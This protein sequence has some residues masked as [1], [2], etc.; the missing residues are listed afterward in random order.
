MR[1]LPF[2]YPESR[3][4]GFNHLIFISPI[5]A[6]IALVVLIIAL[7]VPFLKNSS[8]SGERLANSFS[9]LYFENKNKY[10]YLFLT[11]LLGSVLFYLFRAPTHFLGDGY[12]ALNNLASQ[13]GTIFKWS[14]AGTTTLLDSI[15]SLFGGK[16]IQTAKY[17]FQAVSIISGAISIFFFIL[18]SGEISKNSTRRFLAFI[19]MFGS[20]VLLMFFGY[21]ESYSPAWAA[22]SGFIYFT[23]RYLNR[24]RGLIYIFIFLLIGI[25]FHLQMAIYIPAV[26]Y[27]LF[28][29]ER[30]KALYKKNGRIIKVIIAVTIGFA[31]YVFV[32][33][34]HSDL[35]F[36]NI[37]LPLFSGKPA[38]PYYSLFSLPHLLDVL[39]QLLLLS[40]LL[41]LLLY[42]SFGGIKNSIK[43]RKVLALG[44]MAG[45]IL[46]FLLIIDPKL[47]MPRDWDLFSFSALPLTLLL[48]ILIPEIKLKGLSKYFYIIVL[49]LIVAVVP[50]LITNLGRNSSISY[51][52]YMI[53]LDLPKAQSSILALRDYYYLVNDPLRADSLNVFYSDN[54]WNEK[55]IESAFS[56]LDNNKLKLA[57][58]ILSSIK[59][60]KFFSKY[61]NLKSEI[62]FQQGKSTL[63]LEESKKAIQL[64]QYDARLYSNQAV[65]YAAREEYESAYQAL[66]KGYRLDSLN[67]DLIAG[68]AGYHL[69]FGSPDS[70]LIYSQKMIA[71]DST[72]AYAY[73]M[74]AEV[75]GKQNSLQKATEYYNL[76][77]KYKRS[78]SASDSSSSEFQ[79]RIEN[80]RENKQ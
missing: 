27:I 59:P 3:M 53:N 62:Y 15:Q 19:C 52:K 42:L 49:Y 46:I 50:F 63:A 8:Q 34:Y 41:P 4:F 68:L 32:K 60:D 24:E 28:S 6:I 78:D 2:L 10:S 12:T 72:V 47:G 64:R 45:A 30:G 20:A 31:I 54:F 58:T 71:I 5:Y 1:F 61:H 35:Y 7:V 9:S 23:L 29:G 13:S 51:M 48:I 36:E 56:A 79:Q 18:I 66:K 55:R 37:F 57:E 17:A 38:S 75:Y 77:L 22:F 21:V 14:E 26:I 73:H 25:L 67:I 76:Y 11:I 43:N 33:K 44:L 39:N 40:P 16:N 74:M 70:V 65:I 80:I 69:A